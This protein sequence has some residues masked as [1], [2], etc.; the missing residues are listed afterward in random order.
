VLTVCVLIPSCHSAQGPEATPIWTA[1]LPILY[2]VFSALIG[3]Q[4]VLFS[5]TLAVLLR[6]TVQG[7]NQVSVFVQL[8]KHRLMIQSSA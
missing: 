6:S 7:E 3:T 1:A 5:K 4:S 2:S 8:S